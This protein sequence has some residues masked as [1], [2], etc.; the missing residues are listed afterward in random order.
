MVADDIRNPRNMSAQ[1]QS[2]TAETLGVTISPKLI[3]LIDK[4][5]E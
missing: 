3:P 1:Q 4:V 2:A 5:V